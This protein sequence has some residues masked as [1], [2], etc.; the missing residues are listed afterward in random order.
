[1]AK[2][3]LF[4]FEVKPGMVIAE[5]LYNPAGQLVLPAGFVLDEATISKLEYYTIL[6]VP[7]DDS[8]A[9]IPMAKPVE[10][11]HLDNENYSD[12]LK[13]SVEFK[14]FR[15]DYEVSISHLANILN[16]ASTTGKPID[17]ESIYKDAEHLINSSKNTIHIFDF[18]HNLRNYDDIIA[19]HCQNV[20]LISNILGQW[21]GVTGDDLKVLTTA[22]LLHDIGKLTIPQQILN[23]PG[24]LSDEEYALMRDHVKRGYQLL[25]EQP[26]DIRIKEVCLLHHE[27]CDGSGYPFH[28]EASRI[29]PF[30]K[31][32]AIADVYDAMTARR[33]YRGALCP[34]DVI[35]MFDEEGLNKYD[36]HYIMTFLNR[37]TS[38]Y[39]HNNVRL[40]DGREGE[41]VMINPMC[42]YRPM[43]RVGSE[44]IDLLKNPN[45]KIEAILRSEEH[46]SELQS[47]Q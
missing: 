33:S 1:M 30:A 29:T 27:R 22:G 15:A 24:R 32:V 42:L 8:P 20:A 3:V 37:I 12:R 39:L 7:V 23:K 9:S 47:L 34:F 26:I 2:K 14:Q 41:I 45:L 35:Q 4:S 10:T 40:N 28:A 13:N 11:A 31:I 21:L 19:T 25:K 16:E 17:T 36:P 6:E 43:V 44:F 46:T 5:D 18:I 38:S